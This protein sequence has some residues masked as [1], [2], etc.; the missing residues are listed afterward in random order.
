MYFFYFYGPSMFC[1]LPFVF[2]EGYLIY[3]SLLVFSCEWISLFLYGGVICF[4]VPI[5]PLSSLFLYIILQDL[6]L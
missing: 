5:S 2:F 3:S 4:F 6:I 1:K